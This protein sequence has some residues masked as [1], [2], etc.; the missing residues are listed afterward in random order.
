M[1]K[2]GVVKS[3]TCPQFSQSFHFKIENSL[4]DITNICVSVFEVKKFIFI[5]FLV[6]K[7]L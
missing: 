2:T 1:K 5:V 6:Q 4:L 3:D 7:L